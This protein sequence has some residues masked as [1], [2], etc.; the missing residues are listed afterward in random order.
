MNRYELGPN[1][2]ADKPLRDTHGT[3]IDQDYIDQAVD[4]AHQAVTGRPSLAGHRCGPS[5]QVAFRLPA[6]ERERAQR[7]AEAEGVSLSE[8][9]RQALEERIQRAS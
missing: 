5:P 6:A 1:I 3:L 2:P 8:L 9:A 4:D 7:L